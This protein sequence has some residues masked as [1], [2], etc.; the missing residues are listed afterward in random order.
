MRLVIV[1]RFRPKEMTTANGLCKTNEPV[2]FTSK[3]REDMLTHTQPVT[4]FTRDQQS[5]L[6]FN[7]T[8]SF[9]LHKTLP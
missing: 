7:I 5:D 9:L 6:A 4:L 3:R 2:F 8:I 1:F